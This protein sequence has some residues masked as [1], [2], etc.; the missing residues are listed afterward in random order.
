MELNIQNINS[1]LVEAPIGHT[2]ATVTFDDAVLACHPPRISPGCRYMGTEVNNPVLLTYLCVKITT[3][4]KIYNGVKMLL[5]PFP[6][7]RRHVSHYLVD[8]FL[9]NSISKLRKN[10]FPHL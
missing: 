4:L 2:R 9:L 7:T 6:I 10:N 8:Y 1:Q 5:C 3:F